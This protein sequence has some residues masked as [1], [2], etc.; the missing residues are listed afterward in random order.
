[1]IGDEGA[2]AICAAALR[3]PSLTDLALQYCEISTIPLSFQLAPHSISVRLWSNPL[4]SP[5]AAIANIE[6]GWSVSVA[7][8]AKYWADLRAEHVPLDCVRLM[9]V[10]YGGVGKTTLA[11]AL[12]LSSEQLSGFQK[13]LKG[14]PRAVW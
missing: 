11:Q 12:R 7:A 8:I 1:M 10:G 2:Q 4:R 14:P 3:C 13:S 5:P 9:L 6:G